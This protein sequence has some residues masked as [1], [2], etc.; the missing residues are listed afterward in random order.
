MGL[1][2]SQAPLTKIWMMWL[3]KRKYWVLAWPA[4]ISTQT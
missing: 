3:G 2:P 1:G 4:T